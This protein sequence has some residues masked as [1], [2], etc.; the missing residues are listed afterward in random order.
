[1]TM[2]TTTS[3]WLIKVRCRMGSPPSG[4]RS[5]RVVRAQHHPA[6]H[7]DPV[8]VDQIVGSADGGGHDNDMS[9]S[10]MGVEPTSTLVAL[11]DA[12][13]GVAD[14]IADDVPNNNVPAEDKIAHGKIAVGNDSHVRVRRLIFVHSV[15]TSRDATELPPMQT[16][17]LHQQS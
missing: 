2:L 9:P 6:A 8:N 12:A 17:Y 13:P 7:D 15:L 5:H 16:R 4:L 1:M 3:N 11:A 14:R 10:P